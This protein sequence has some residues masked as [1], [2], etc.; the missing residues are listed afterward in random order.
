MRQKQKIKKVNI[1]EFKRNCVKGSGIKI[2][3]L[4]LTIQSR[5]GYIKLYNR[6]IIKLAGQEWEIV[7]CNFLLKK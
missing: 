5:C 1:L 7:F 4:Y 2:I 3:K 6:K